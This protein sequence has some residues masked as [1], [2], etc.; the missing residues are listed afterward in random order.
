M[1]IRPATPAD[2]PAL[3]PVFEAAKAIMRADGNPT[4]W[5]APGFPSDTLLLRDIARGGGFVIESRWPVAAGH[6]DRATVMPGAD[7]SVIPGLTR[8]LPEPR[9]VAYFALLPSPEPTYDYIDGAWLTDEPYGVIHRM[10]SYPEVHGIFSAIID[11]AAS[12][13]SHLRIDTHRDNHIMQ[14][15]I[16]KHNFTYCGIIWLEDGTERLAYER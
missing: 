14:H 10:A 6:D 2:L 12:R 5:A 8:N 3:R 15:L 16:E 4:Q 1:V 7:S 11:Y 9:L 13:Y